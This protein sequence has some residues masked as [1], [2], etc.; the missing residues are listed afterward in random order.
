MMKIS[1]KAK[2]GQAHG[3]Q[4]LT[5]GA[6]PDWRGTDVGPQSGKQ[7]AFAARPIQW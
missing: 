6:A 2:L 1:R 5:G 4:Y 7:T 3:I